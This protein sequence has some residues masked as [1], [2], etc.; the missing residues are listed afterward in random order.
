M[1]M[2]VRVMLAALLLGVP[3][4]W[5]PVAETD[6]A[7]QF[8]AV[9]SDVWG[10]LADNINNDD[11]DELCNSGNPRKRKKCIYN[12]WESHIRDG[13]DNG[14]D[15]DVVVMSSSTTIP[16]LAM[17]V[18]GLTVELTR[19][20]ETPTINAPFVVGIKGTG[21]AIAQV[22]WWVE[23][24]VPSGPFADD[25]AFTG[26]A[27]YD[28]AGAQPCAWSWPVVARYLGPYMLHAKVRDTNGREVQTDWK[29]DTIE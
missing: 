25:L 28:C 17:T 22:S 1:R 15:N 9:P 23:G 12:G 7:P 21:A 5:L 14:N 19:T 4:F 8:A 18:D 2:I 27:T 26:T 10:P 6:A 11:P 29:F 16:G 3:A 24:P 13:N 20:A